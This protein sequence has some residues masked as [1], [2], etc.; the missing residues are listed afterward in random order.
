[1][2]WKKHNNNNSSKH[3]SIEGFFLFLLLHWS[4]NI[5]SLCGSTNRIHNNKK[6]LFLVASFF[7]DIRDEKS[8][9][10]LDIKKK[11]RYWFRWC[12]LLSHIWNK[13]KQKKEQKNIIFF[14]TKKRYFET[15]DFRGGL[16]A[17]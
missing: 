5:D 4:K 2:L 10:G 14:L 13:R 16:V 8:F 11:D 9:L 1:L 7:K 3:H 15:P 6:R 12:V 17:G